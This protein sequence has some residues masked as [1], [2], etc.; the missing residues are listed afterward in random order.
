MVLLLSIF[1][2]GTHCQR[3][4]PQQGQSWISLGL[5]RLSIYNRTNFI[6]YLGSLVQLAAF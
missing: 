5:E 6:F 3:L 4:L 2:C 1:F